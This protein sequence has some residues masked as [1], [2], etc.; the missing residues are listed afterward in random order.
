[1]ELSGEDKVL[2][3][4]HRMFGHRRGEFSDEQKAM[5]LTLQHRGLLGFDLTIIAESVRKIWP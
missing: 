2:V 4:W 3:G 5:R 1:M